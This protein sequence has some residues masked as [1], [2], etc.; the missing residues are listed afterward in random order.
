[1]LM[2]HSKTKEVLTTDQHNQETRVDRHLM[3]LNGLKLVSTCVNIH[4]N[5]VLS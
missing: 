2:V 5:D 1:M 3:Y 4:S